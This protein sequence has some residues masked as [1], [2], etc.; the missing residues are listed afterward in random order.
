[1]IDLRPSVAG[2]PVV[3]I[4]NPV[5]G[6]KTVYDNLAIVRRTP[7]GTPIVFRDTDWALE[8]VLSYQF[9]NLTLVNIDALK[10]LLSGSPGLRMQMTDYEAATL[11]GYIMTPVFNIA[12][13]HDT[14][15]HSFAFDFLV[16]GYSAT[17]DLI[18]QTQ[19]GDPVET[20]VPAD[21][22]VES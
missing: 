2:T 4:R 6:N 7:A 11:Y 18:I 16:D 10:T 5:L 1:M 17:T 15:T 14:C 12:Q 3:T 13:Q 19:S 9:T 22:L 8:Q 20:E 21:L